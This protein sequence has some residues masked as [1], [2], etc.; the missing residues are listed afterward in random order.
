MCAIAHQTQDHRFIKT[1]GINIATFLAMAIFQK[2]SVNDRR[3]SED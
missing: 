3:T 2:I 1:N